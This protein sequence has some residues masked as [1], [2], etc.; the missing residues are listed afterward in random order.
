MKIVA[1][2]TAFALA[3]ALGNLPAEAQS[4]RFP[5]QVSRVDVLG[6]EAEIGMIIGASMAPDGGVYVVDHMNARLIAFD[7]NGR[8][9]WQAGR[10]G[11]GPGEFN[12]PY[13]VAAAP[14]GAVYVFDLAGSEIS[15]FSREGRFEDRIRLPF[16]LVQADQMLVLAGNRILVA[17]HAPDAAHPHEARGRGVHRFTWRNRSLTYGGSFGPL[18]HARDPQVLRLWGAGNISPG[19]DETI[20]FARRSPYE[21]FRYDANG[22]ERGLLRPPFR[23][24]G[25]PDD[26]FSITTQGLETRYSTG[27]GEVVY[28]GAVIQLSPDL[29]LV[30]RVTGEGRWWDL[31][32]TDGRFISSRRVPPEWGSPFA[33][34]AARGVLWSSGIAEE[35]PVL[36]RLSIVVPPLP[37][38]RS[39]S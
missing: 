38:R 13:R 39:R 34:D 37:T 36:L 33:Y 26:A 1:K 8:V 4:A 11:R 17:G 20:W 35:E 14:D 31:F 3:C 24:V 23:S 22:R 29:V 27:S 6:R 5:V 32:G 2:L 15:R 9:R 28:P 21:V 30:V 19:M 10:K 12:M 7:A 16:A 18:P 25:T